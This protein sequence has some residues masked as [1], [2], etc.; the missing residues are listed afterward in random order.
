MARS[1]LATNQRCV[2]QRPDGQWVA[3]VPIEGRIKP[4]GPF[5][6]ETEAVAAYGYV[7]AAFAGAA[8]AESAA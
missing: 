2:R 6:S 4:V 1:L 7:L 5:G 3:A 8:G